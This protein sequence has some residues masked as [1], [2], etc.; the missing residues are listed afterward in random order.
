MR[1][2]LSRRLI[3]STATA[4]LLSMPTAPPPALA[5]AGLPKEALSAKLSRVPVFVVTNKQA[6][7]YLTEVDGAG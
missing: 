6:A 1:L 4:A 5:A 7:P 3:A 2:D